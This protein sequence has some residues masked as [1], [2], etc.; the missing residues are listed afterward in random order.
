MISYVCSVAA[1]LH[2]DDYVMYFETFVVRLFT[3]LVFACM[4]LCVVFLGILS[5]DCPFR[6]YIYTLMYVSCLRTT[7]V[8]LYAYATYYDKT[9]VRMF[10]FFVSMLLRVLCLC[11]I[12]ACVDE[13]RYV[14]RHNCMCRCIAC[15]MFCVITACVD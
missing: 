6:I 1:L 4:P 14:L 5:F 15:I 11:V 10:F 2:S 13:F 12:V 9:F 7:C 8:F 3:T